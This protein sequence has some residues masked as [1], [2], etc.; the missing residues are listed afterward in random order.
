MLQKVV[1]LDRDGVINRDSPNYI[2]SWAEFSFLP[3]S[4]AA[5][6]E[7]TVNGF[8][9]FIVTNQSIIH[10]KMV[11][12]TTVNTIHQ[13]MTRAIE[14][15]GG[16]VKDIFFC[17]HTP[18]QNCD[19]RKPKPGLI[20][21]ARKAY[22]IDLGT[23]FM[24]GDSAKDIECGKNA[25]CR[26]TLLVKTGSGH[27]SEQILREKNRLPDHVAKDLAAAAAWIINTYNQIRAKQMI[28]P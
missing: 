25:G 17:P 4:K 26:F 11:P 7:L 13:K 2:K 12:L 10:R 14:S 24:V 18:D 23:S 3:G 1:F 9:L 5:I 15:A 21:M 16:A 8:A 27:L 6:K 22:D 19:C 28:V 20:Q